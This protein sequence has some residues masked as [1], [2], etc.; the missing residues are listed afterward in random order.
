MQAEQRRPDHSNKRNE[1]CTE[2]QPDPSYNTTGSGV[3]GFTKQVNNIAI[4]PLDENYFASAGSTG[5]P[6]VNV[7][8]KRWFTRLNN[9]S[10]GSDGGAVLELRPAVDNSVTTSVWSVRYSGLKRGRFC[11]L[12]ST[13]EVKLF[14]TAC[15]KDGARNP[16][17]R[18]NY[19]GG[20]P[21]N[22]PHYISRTHNLQYPHH[23]EHGSPEDERVIAFDWLSAGIG[24][25]QAMLALRPSRDIDLLHVPDPCHINL[26]S[27]DDLAVSRSD[28]TIFEPKAADASI[29]EDVLAVR[30]QMQSVMLSP[31]RSPAPTGL[32]NGKPS[33]QLDQQTLRALRN[34]TT[35]AART[36][37]WVE[38]DYSRSRDVLR[39]HNFPEALTL[40]S[41]QRRRCQEGYLFDCS[42]NMQIVADDPSLVR[43]WATIKRLEELAKDG[44]MVAESLDLS[45][46]GVEAI[47]KSQLGDSP[48]RVVSQRSM[49]PAKIGDSIKAL[50]D[51]HGLPSFE[52]INTEKPKKRLL[53]L[54]MCGWAFTRADAEVQCEELLQTQEYWRA[55]ALA[56]FQRHK[57]LGLRL[58]QGLIRE[59]TLPNNGLTAFLAADTLNADQR[60]M[61]GWLAEEAQ[62]PYLRAL[63]SHLA[64]GGDWDLLIDNVSL[65]LSTRVGIALAHLPDVSLTSFI[66]TSAA[67]SI[68]AGDPEG[69]LLTGLT[70]S[71]MPLFQAYIT[72]TSDLQTAVL[73]TAFT[74]PLYVNDVRWEMWRETYFQQLQAW[75]AFI[76]RT[77]FSMLHTRLATTQPGR[78]LTQPP[79]PQIRLRCA[80]CS[81]DLARRREDGETAT[82][83]RTHTTTSVGKNGDVEAKIAQGAG[84]VCPRCGRHLPRCAVCMQWL[85]TPDPSNTPAV[86]EGGPG[87]G[88]GRGEGGV[89]RRSQGDGGDVLA[90]FATF[91]ISCGHGFHASHARTWFRKHGMCPVPDCQCLCGLKG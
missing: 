47:W 66:T 78:R 45:Y 23:S 6:S 57:N 25:R 43:M 41:V 63:F 80:N 87:P 19:Y 8:D 79:K 9:G 22:S 62:D 37:Q 58:L 35:P 40:L 7:W 51:A 32:E 59:K 83:K 81:G 21:W 44:G 70:S 50:A 84:T 42:K 55:I 18:T 11:T 3:S 48:N 54:E 73:A 52:G 14:D 90:R 20:N 46:L 1:T 36:A 77:R 89:G 86:Q 67:A 68:S 60:E 75:R 30:E 17:V 12:S 34:S 88:G 76:P 26:T 56:V 53:C 31:V 85:G 27:K 24:G 5:D 72:R 74:N 15:F 13:G 82:H 69:I 16:T 28:I 38:A 33:E 2:P 49:V 65:D 4:D 10:A 29:A 71:S 39:N 64:S 61:C 91:C